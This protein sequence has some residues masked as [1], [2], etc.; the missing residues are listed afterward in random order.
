MKGRTAYRA[1]VDGL[2]AVAVLLVVLFHAGVPWLPGGFIGVDIFFVISGYLITRI[3]KDETDRTGSLDLLNFYAR[4]ARRLLPAAALVTLVTLAVNSRILS[5]METIRLTKPAAATALYA[6]NVW[7]ILQGGDYFGGDLNSNPFLHTWSLAVE[8]QFFLIW[9]LLVWLAVRWFRRPAVVFGVVSAASLLACV[10]MTGYRPLWA[11]YGTPFRI[12]EF[13]AGALTCLMPVRETSAAGKWTQTLGWAGVALAIVPALAFTSGTPFP[14]MAALIPV[15]GTMAILLS[16]K[17]VSFL[18]WR[19]FTGLGKISYSFY[20]WHWPMLTAAA[21]LRPEI[22]TVTRLLVVAAAIPL[23]AASMMLVEKPVRYSPWL[24]RRSMISMGLAAATAGFVLLAV[25]AARWQS[26]S[27]AESPSQKSIIAAGRERTR[28]ANGCFANGGNDQVAECTFGPATASRT[29]VL[30]GDSHAE[31]LFPALEPLAASGSW[32]VVTMVRASCPTASVDVYNS[33][34]KKIDGPCSRWRGKAL[35]RIQT[36]RS[37]LV[38]IANEAGYAPASPLEWGQGTRTTLARLISGGTRVLV[39]RDT[40]HPNLDVP[41]CLSRA[42]MRGLRPESECIVQRKLALDESIW[43]AEQAAGEGLA[44]VSFAD[45]TDLFCDATFCPT[46][47]NG[48]PVYRDTDHISA[49]F[50]A[51]L[52]GPL[53]A[54]LN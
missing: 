27:A 32:K 35:D 10:W 24:A 45:F 5:P 7:F 4:R 23:A 17:S 53:L 29:L 26:G 31:Q 15:I 48:T 11:F 19:P 3:L 51:R 6:S 33:H 2:R 14:G 52:A 1:E 21:V 30:F 18:S 44:G 43:N 28:L 54:R 20:L 40:P 16:G 13:A 47:R 46:I 9:P 37:E 8:E 38:V 22:D 12:W 34:L 50:A 25:G 41:V 36:I 49:A 42:A 39:V